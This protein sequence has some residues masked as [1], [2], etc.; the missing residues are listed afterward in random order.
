MEARGLLEPPVAGL[1]AQKRTDEQITEIESVCVKL[2]HS[3][4]LQ[5]FD[6]YFKFDKAFHTLLIQATQNGLL[7]TILLPLINTMDQRLYREFT[8]DFYIKDLQALNELALLHQEIFEAVASGNSERATER[9]Q[10]HWT[11]MWKV[12]QDQAEG[13]KVV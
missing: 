12:I 7:A 8:K 3:A 1:A 11:R 6:E 5:D 9:M 10:A 13:K 2:K 4:R